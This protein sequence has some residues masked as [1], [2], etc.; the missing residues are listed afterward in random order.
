MQL[1]YIWVSNFRNISY[2]GFNISS[3]YTIKFD[4]ISGEL[5]IKN[6]KDYVSDFFPNSII[7]VTAIVGENGT[8]KTNILELIN[9]M[10]D[11]GN[12]K[13]SQSFFLIFEENEEFTV[14]QNKMEIHYSVRNGKRIKMQDYN[15]IKTPMSAIFFT[16]TFDGR[17]YNF[18]KKVFN[19]STNNLYQNEY[20]DF[21]IIKVKEEILNQLRFLNNDILNTNQ[22]KPFVDIHP[23][24]VILIAPTWNILLN[25]CRAFD[26]K[27]VQLGIYRTNELSKFCS[28]FRKKITLSESS[29]SLS[30][31][32]SF[33]VFLDFV[34][35]DMLPKERK[36]PGTPGHPLELRI[37]AIKETLQFLNIERMSE[38]RINEIH[39]FITNKVA[40]FISNDYPKCEKKT[41]FLLN[42]GIQKYYEIDKNNEGSY[43]NRNIKFEA[44]FTEEIVDFVIQYTRSSSGFT[45][46][47]SIE[48]GGISSGQKAFL[49]LYSR[50]YS[51]QKKIT[52]EN[53]LITI[54]E[55]DLYFHPKWQIE[56]L[57]S[58]IQILPKIFAQ[59][60]QLIL[61]THSPFLVSDLTKN[62][63][64]YIENSLSGCQIL[65]KETIEENT[66]GGNIGELYLNTFFLKGSLISSFAAIKI[67][68][69]IK[70]AK[71][72]QESWTSTDQKL[73]NQIGDKIIKF[74]I[75]R[76]LN[77]KN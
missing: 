39:E 59:R 20:G 11:E 66:F 61:T 34:L 74:E 16:N 25:K 52:K 77:G 30:Y 29:R 55:G 35:N 56:Y 28:K 72:S 67:Q 21:S 36:V 31:F 17:R 24:S 73:L 3:R 48:W 4:S 60:I 33:L 69:L 9:F 22:K 53:I 49:N 15:N 23:T 2:Q 5:S 64:I 50:L 27:I 54:D 76:I 68:D 7:N 13:I 10:M 19:L 8:G 43:T 57:N 18:G 70:K 47:F 62:H 26:K 44:P 32:T 42:L 45:P 1:V 41:K 14:I 63:L 51:V 46:N 40:Y 75:Q 6:N 71:N 38:M 12:T 37:E 58:L 65:E